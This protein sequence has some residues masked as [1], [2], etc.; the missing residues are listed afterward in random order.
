MSTAMEGLSFSSNPIS[1]SSDA[2]AHDSELAEYTAPTTTI[3]ELHIP[4]Q[5]SNAL[6]NSFDFSR[7]E[8]L[9]FDI[10]FL[11]ISD[12]EVLALSRNTLTSL[13]VGPR[14]ESDY[15]FAQ[16]RPD[17][18]RGFLLLRSLHIVSSVNLDD[19]TWV[20][21]Q[22]SSAP[23]CLE[24][25]TLSLS[26]LDGEDSATRL[27]RLHALASGVVTLP[28]QA[29]RQLDICLG[30]MVDTDK[31]EILQE[32]EIQVVSVPN[33]TQPH[34]CGNT[35]RFNASFPRPFRHTKHKRT[36]RSPD[37]VELE[38]VYP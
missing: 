25:V 36:M 6:I 23:D 37:S 27:G 33:E 17:L 7:L 22:I 2:W 14:R 18:L 4:L 21:E 3:T 24:T 30:L 28:L 34:T 9:E 15:F 31:N 20:L 13:K 32:V 38:L 10:Q 8:K 11:D 26:D 12:A 35:G 1:T 19:I 29:L 16:D 5:E